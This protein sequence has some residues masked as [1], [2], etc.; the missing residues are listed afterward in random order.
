MK[1][2]L[3]TD[4]FFGQLTK[5][6]FPTDKF[7]FQQTLFPPLPFFGLA[8][9]EMSGHSLEWQGKF[10]N[11][12]FFPNRQKTIPTD[13]CFLFQQT[14]FF[15]LG[16]GGFFSASA[17]FRSCIPGNVWTFP[18]M[19]GQVFQPTFFS[20]TNKKKFPPDKYFLFQRTFFFPLGPRG[21]FSTSAVFR[22]N[23]SKSEPKIP[24]NHRF[25]PVG[26]DRK[27]KCEESC[28]KLSRITW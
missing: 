19:G 27:K 23:L 14:F 5:L 10:S 12:H 17:V 11:Q 22:W 3:P 6:I 24:L 4:I 15:P 1:I 9:Q 28:G 25:R 18:G 20:P 2:F 21:V 8:F 16:P 13:K 7:I 26:T